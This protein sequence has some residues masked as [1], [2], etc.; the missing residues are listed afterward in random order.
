MLCDNDIMEELS[1]TYVRA[2]ASHARFS[3]EEVRR[4][5]DSIDLHILAKGSLGGPLHSPALAV[6]LKSTGMT[7][8]DLQ[9]CS[10]AHSFPFDL[11]PKNFNDLSARTLI[12]RVLVV[13][14]MPKDPE[15]WLTATQ[16]ALTLRRAA[17]WCSLLG[18]AATSNKTSARVHVPW[19]QV[20]DV[21]GIRALLGRVSRQEEILP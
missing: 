6:Q 19:T 5:R 13:F 4:D 1:L 21:D 10:Q 9:R 20:F 17:Y 12:P 3:V 18:N 2:V 15:E 11:K 7:D 14:L 8:E 16:E